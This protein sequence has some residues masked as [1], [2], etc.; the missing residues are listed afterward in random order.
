MARSILT[1][2]SLTVYVLWLTSKRGIEAET[3][4]SPWGRQSTRVRSF[5]KQVSLGTR[6]GVIFEA[7]DSDFHHAPNVTSAS[8]VIRV[9]L[10]TAKQIR[11]DCRLLKL[12]EQPSTCDIKT[13]NDTSSNSSCSNS[14]VVSCSLPCIIRYD[15]DCN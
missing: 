1:A 4:C 5:T 13:E 7:L 6:T 15:D 12:M 3:N 9:Q 2:L 11:F 10:T 14:F 8:P